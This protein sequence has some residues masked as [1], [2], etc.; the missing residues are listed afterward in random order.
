MYA[1]DYLPNR[2]RVYSPE[3]IVHVL[4]P[5]EHNIWLTRQL[6][7]WFRTATDV[8]ENER[9]LNDQNVA[10]R[11][12]STEELDRPENRRR[13]EQQAAA[14]HTN[15]R[16]LDS[17]TDAGNDLIREALKNEEFNPAT[18][19]TWAEMLNALQQIADQRMP[20]VADLLAAAAKSPAAKGPSANSQPKP[21]SQG[22]R[23]TRIRVSETTAARLRELRARRRSA[24]CRR[25]RASRMWSRVQQA[26]S[27]SSGTAS[28]V[29]GEGRQGLLTTTRRAAVRRRNHRRAASRRGDD[30][31]SGGSAAGPVERV[32]PCRR[33]AAAD[34]R[35]PRG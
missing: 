8:Y 11:G 10:L 29:A 1:D 17:V 32:R 33:R 9:R 16:R 34:S 31:T 2:E 30:R 19:E 24:K 13:I 18:L 35:Q 5:E 28:T 15:A 3:Y 6:S 27:S 14:E 4:S 7:R 25:F 21:A 23:R 12:M 20:S 26:Q 22:I